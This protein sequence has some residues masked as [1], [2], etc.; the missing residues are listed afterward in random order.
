MNSPDP[1]PRP[2]VIDRVLGVFFLLVW[3]VPISYTA[4]VG[5][6]G[7]WLPINLR[8]LYS[9]SC[10]FDDR[11]ERFTS[12]VVQ[13]RYADSVAWEDFEEEAFFPMQPFGHRSR[14]D[15]L[16][17][18]FLWQ[19]AR[20]PD[21][22]ELADWI[23]RRHQTLNPHRPAIVAVRYMAFDTAI[24]PEFPPEGHWHK[25]RA[26]EVQRPRLHRIGSM[27]RVRDELGSGP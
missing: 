26:S 11:S 19:E 4:F 5:Y 15:R 20:E 17:S 21:R 23:A 22:Q 25:P 1:R 3:L 13:V 16:F 9:V 10:L 2:R 8:D 12:F 7:Q 24:D 27:C 6:P 14:L 18:R